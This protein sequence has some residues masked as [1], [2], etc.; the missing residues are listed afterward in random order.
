[1]WHSIWLEWLMW[2]FVE[3]YL[4][5]WSFSIQLNVLVPESVS[6]CASLNRQLKSLHY[7]ICDYQ[8]IIGTLNTMFKVNHGF[9]YEKKNLSF[10]TLPIRFGIHGLHII[11]NVP[12]SCQC[13]CSCAM[14]SKNTI[15][16]H[17][18]SSLE[19]IL[20]KLVYIHSRECILLR[21]QW[22]L[23]DICDEKIKISQIKK[24][25]Q[26]ALSSR[27][28]NQINDE[29]LIENGLNLLYVILRII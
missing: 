1:M 2:R 23:S 11:F 19:I 27:I 5:L 28:S 26:F 8:S 7:I 9:R 25:K 6:V 20:L 18:Y 17:A 13:W 3:I 22:S 14:N 21:N 4:H 15:N 16:W 24:M 10:L 12:C 29:L